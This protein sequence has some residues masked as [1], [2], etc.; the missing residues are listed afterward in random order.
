MMSSFWVAI[1]SLMNRVVLQICSSS[2]EIVFFI[3]STQGLFFISQ[4]IPKTI[5]ARPSPT[6]MRDRSSSKAVALQW[7]QVAAVIRPCLFGVPSSFKAVRGGIDRKGRRRRLTR[8]GSIKFPVAPQSM[9]AV[10]TTVLA[11][12]LRRIGNWIA[13]SD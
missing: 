8:E 5:W 13:L 11:L 10:V 2:N 3:Q 6:T 12:C 9:M 7:T 4:G 1:A